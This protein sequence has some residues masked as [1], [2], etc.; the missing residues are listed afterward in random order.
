MRFFPIKPASK[1][2]NDVMLSNAKNIVFSCCYEIL[3]YGQ[4]D[5][6]IAGFIIDLKYRVSVSHTVHYFHNRTSRTDIFCHASIN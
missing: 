1:H 5:R 3:H 2:S 4:D 6:I